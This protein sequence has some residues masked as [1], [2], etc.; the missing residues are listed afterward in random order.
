MPTDARYCEW[1][2][3]KRIYHTEEAAKVVAERNHQRAYQCPHCGFWHLTRRP[4][5]KRGHRGRVKH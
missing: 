1:P 4:R 2:P 3:L 5:G